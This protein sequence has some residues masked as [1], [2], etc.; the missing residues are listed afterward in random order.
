MHPPVMNQAG[1]RTELDLVWMFF[2]KRG[3]SKF[4]YGQ[5]SQFCF[6]Y[7]FDNPAYKDLRYVPRLYTIY[8]K[9]HFHPS[10]LILFE[11]A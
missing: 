1:P 9:P 10:T 11:M 5:L 8:L 3:S 2:H 7:E 6:A 4:E